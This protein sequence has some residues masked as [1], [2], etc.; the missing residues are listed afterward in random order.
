MPWNRCS[1]EA[2]Q[3]ASKRLEIRP[4]RRASR[5]RSETGSAAAHNDEDKRVAA[6][7]RHEKDQRRQHD[8][9]PECAGE[10]DRQ[11]RENRYPLLCLGH[12][13]S[14]LPGC[15][16]FV[17]GRRDSRERHGF[18]VATTNDIVPG[19]VGPNSFGRALRVMRCEL[20]NADWS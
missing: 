16:G 19:F 15:I 2:G 20:A 18:A 7:P 3:A 10:I 9:E 12:D 4:T 13:A 11:D 8:T 1:P 5:A 6:E 17:E 14:N